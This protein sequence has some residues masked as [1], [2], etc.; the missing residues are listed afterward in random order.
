VRYYLAIC[1]RGKNEKV[2]IS[3]SQRRCYM[4]VCSISS[5]S[6]KSFYHSSSMYFRNRL[7]TSV[8]AKVREI[9]VTLETFKSFIN[10]LQLF[11][12]PNASSSPKR[13]LA[14]SF[15]VS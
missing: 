15:E 6:F 4:F 9:N 14:S 3:I 8:N 13:D 12:P 7:Q 2:I 1:Y 11:H 5:R 10:T